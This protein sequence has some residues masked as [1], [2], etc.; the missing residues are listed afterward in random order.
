M[1]RKAAVIALIAGIGC[2]A[3]CSTPSLRIAVRKSSTLEPAAGVVLL[4]ATKGPLQTFATDLNGNTVWQ[5]P[6]DSHRGKYQPMPVEALPNGHMLIVSAYGS[7]IR[8]CSTCGTDNI[9]REIDL[10]GHTV[11]QLTNA[12]LQEKLLV[13][14]YHIRLTQM[15]HDALPLPNAHLILLASDDK[16]VRLSGRTGTTTVR[17]AAL[18][19]LDANRNPVWVWDTFGHLDPNRHPYFKLPDWIHGN[20]VIYSPDDGNLVFSSRAQSWLIKI[21]YQNGRGSGNVIW[22]LGYQGDF[23]LTKGGPAAWFYGQHAPIFVSRNSTGVFRIAVFDNGNSRI[24]TASGA[25]CGTRGQPACYSTVPV[26]EVD[27]ANH[28]A[29]V[30]WRDKLPFFSFAVGNVQVFD[31]GDVWFDA[32]YVNGKTTVIRE[33]TMAPTPQTVIEMDVNR[34]VYRAIHL[35]SLGQKE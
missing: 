32:G 19:D 12:E 14:G 34:A 35:P 33:V 22:R 6:F 5:Y 23:V 15:S 27:E 2:S 28:R 31:N 7:G 4:S 20:A 13:A 17:G 9:V 11:W 26:Y 18:I 10:A 25:M 24:M 21:D 3:A 30:V 1:K 8:P 16:N 29:T